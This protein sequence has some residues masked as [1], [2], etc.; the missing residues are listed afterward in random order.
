[1]FHRQSLDDHLL[2]VECESGHKCIDLI[3]CARYRI[4]DEIA[5]VSQFKN[6]TH[7]IFVI[8]LPRKRGGTNFVSFQGG[9][10]ECYH[11]DSL[12]A[13]VDPLLTIKIAMDT[14]INDILSDCYTNNTELLHKRLQNWICLALLQSNNVQIEQTVLDRFN[15]LSHLI[16]KAQF[17]ADTQSQ[18]VEQSSCKE[19]C[20]LML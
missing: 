5:Q 8:S 15:L 4:L 1:M 10:W 19:T 18:S 20:K 13:P 9:S 16:K 12:L 7:I 2:I 14:P 11:M 17:T 6:I 3:A